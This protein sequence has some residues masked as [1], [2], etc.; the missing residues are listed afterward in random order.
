MQRVVSVP[1]WGGRRHG[2]DG[3]TRF[4]LYWMLS[5]CPHRARLSLR[6]S[7]SLKRKRKSAQQGPDVKIPTS[8]HTSTNPSKSSRASYESLD[9]AP[10]NRS[11]RRPATSFAWFL[12]PW[13]AFRYILWK[14][15]KW[16]ILGLLVILIILALIVLMICKSS[17][18]HVFSNLSADHAPFF[19]TQKI[20]GGS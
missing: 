1:T 2:N 20:F 16:K 7:F 17:C 13:K 12:S 4:Q 6:S 8:T 18:L 19:V 14:N 3:E 9:L 11:H 10:A 15:Y 5:C